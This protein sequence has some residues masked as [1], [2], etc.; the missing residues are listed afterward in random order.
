[1]PV[2]AEAVAAGE[3]DLD[4]PLGVRLKVFGGWH[5]LSPGGTSLSMDATGVV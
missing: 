5:A 3:F 2:A 4:Q 1:M